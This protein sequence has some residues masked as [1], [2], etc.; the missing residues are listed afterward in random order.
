[1]DSLDIGLLS[2]EETT[3]KHGPPLAFVPLF[4]SRNGRVVQAESLMYDSDNIE[5]DD[6]ESDGEFKRELMKGD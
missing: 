4:V 1:M 2:V 6:L 5:A 3:R